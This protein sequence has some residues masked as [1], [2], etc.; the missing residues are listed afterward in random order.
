MFPSQRLNG[1]IL[2]PTSGD[3]WP[4][5]Q[6]PWPAQWSVSQRIHCY[7]LQWLIY[8]HH[9]KLHHYLPRNKTLLSIV[10]PFNPYNGWGKA[11]V[12]DQVLSPEI[13]CSQVSKMS[14]ALLLPPQTMLVCW[15]ELL[16]NQSMID[17]YLKSLSI[18]ISRTAMLLPCHV[19]VVKIFHPAID[20]V[21]WDCCYGFL[22]CS[23]KLSSSKKKCSSFIN[24]TWKTKEF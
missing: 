15:R 13:F 12:Y 9:P 3:H 18:G 6:S 23:I 4:T 22:S 5:P 16:Q 14:V 10:T 20:V 19:Q 24:Q 8:H 17:K 1:N 2:T 21:S 11:P 7:H